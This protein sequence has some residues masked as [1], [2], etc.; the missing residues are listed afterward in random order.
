MHEIFQPPELIQDG[1][2]SATSTLRNPLST[3]RF[4]LFLLS[5]HAR[6]GDKQ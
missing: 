3:K 5:T 6:L 1:V 4:V 2:D